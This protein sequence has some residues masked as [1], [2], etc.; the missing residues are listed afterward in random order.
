MNLRPHLLHNLNRH[1]FPSQKDF[2]KVL[3][4]IVSVQNDVYTYM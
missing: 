1:Q 2:I 4:I 3:T